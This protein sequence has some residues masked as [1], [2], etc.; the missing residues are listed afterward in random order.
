V[1][2]AL[3]S[4]FKKLYK[5]RILVFVFSFAVIVGEYCVKGI[6]QKEEGGFC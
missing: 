4:P 6:K 1:I 3:T 5:K 2:H